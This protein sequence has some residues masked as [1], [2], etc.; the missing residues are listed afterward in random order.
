VQATK[1]QQ[2][3]GYFIEEA[4]EHLDT[5]EQSLLDL[6]ATMAESERL[7]ELF[8]AAHSVKGGAAMLG[9]SS[10]QKVSHHL[11]DC[12]KLLK[13][14][15]IAVDHQL[16]N[17]F[18]KGFD[19]LKA[20]VEEIQ[21][22]FGLNTETAE[23]IIFEAEPTFA[24]LRGDLD[25]RIRGKQKPANRSVAASSPATV[26]PATVQ[27]TGTELSVLLNSAL[28]M[29]L[30]GFKQGDTP[31]NRQQLTALCI[32]MAQLHSSTEWLV[33]LQMAERAIAN[34]Q[35]PYATLAPLLIKE[36]KQ[37]GDLLVAG[38]A[39]AIVVSQHLQQL[40]PKPQLP[41]AAPKVPPHQTQVARTPTAPPNQ[42]N[43]PQQITIPTEPRAAARALLE[44]FSKQQ[45]IEIADFLMRAIQ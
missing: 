37:A 15:P 26:S 22:P 30:Q 17:L 28:K 3:L 32:R 34:P 5:I 9:F 33:L 18:L 14:H 31:A 16:E 6:Q 23:S 29:M 19:T 24:A 13:D 1:Q 40:T 27:K 20:L 8:R 45:L 41:L 25:R 44:T 4:K 43:R 38:K 21:S 7:N 12:F 11:E 2:I 39:S 36:I 42:S 10:I 35:N